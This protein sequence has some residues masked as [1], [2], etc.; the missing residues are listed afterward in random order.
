MR[1]LISVLL[2]LILL[3]TGI[4]LTASAETVLTG[5]VEGFHRFGNAILSLTPAD[6]RAAGIE[7]GDTVTAEIGGQTYDML[8]ANGFDGLRPGEL[9]LL[10]C[11]INK[12]E[13]IK[14]GLLPI[15]KDPSEAA[16]F[17]LISECVRQA[18]CTNAINACASS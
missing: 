5:T 1:K 8:V 3:T 16:P 18:P 14:T 13:E 9:V 12:I 7:L 4:C 11:N 6:V 2:V 17:G 10:L 15:P